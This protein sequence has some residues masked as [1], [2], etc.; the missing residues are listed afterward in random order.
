MPKAFKTI[1]Q[2]VL[3]LLRNDILSGKYQPGDKLRQDEVA[4][5]FDVSTTPVREAFRGLRSEGLVSIDA[6]KGVVVKGLTVKDV[7]EI[8]ELRIALEPLLAKKAV[9]SIS[10]EALQ[11]ARAIHEEMCASDDP[12]RWSSLNREFHLRLMKSEED[13][14]LYDIV[15][16]LLVVAEPYVSLSIFIHPQILQADN[17]EHGMILDGYTKKNGKQVEKIVK[18]H[19]EQTL[20][21]IQDSVDEETLQLRTPA[22]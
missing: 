11:A 17:D 1:E 2:Y 22:R 15:K 8:Y 20:A 10:P 6:N 5:R 21:A 14:R 13:S 12:H 18:Q 9:S 19:L 16:N 4:R 3:S 7:A